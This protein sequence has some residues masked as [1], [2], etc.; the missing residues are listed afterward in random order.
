MAI[1]NFLKKL[2]SGG[3]SGD[4]NSMYIYVKL[5]RCDEIM[6]VRVNLYNDLSLTD[7]GAYYCRKVVS[8]IRCPFPAEVELYFDKSRRLVESRVDKGE[9]VDEAA[10]L[11]A[12][13]PDAV[14]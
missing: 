2:F 7:D 5:H 8:A 11:A 10:Y 1:V 9:L 6:K 12:T 13:T 3:S 14:E 4:R